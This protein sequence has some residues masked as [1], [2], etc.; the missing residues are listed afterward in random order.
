MTTIKFLNEDACNLSLS[1][2]SV[3]LIITSPPYAGIDPSRYGGNPSKQINANPEMKKTIKLYVKAVKEMERVIKDTGSIIMEIGHPNN[4]PYFLVSEVLKKTNLQLALP[5]FIQS[6]KHVDFFKERN[7]SERFNIAYTLWFHFSKNPDGIYFNPFFIKKDPFL[8]WE[9]DG[10]KEETENDKILSQIGNVSDC[11]N[12][13]IIKRFIETFSKPGQTVLDPFGGSGIT[14][15]TAYLNNRNA[16]TNDIS[17]EQVAVAKKR[18]E[19]E[20]KDIK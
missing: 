16:I 20:V 9:I 4:F 15:L 5:P 13:E 12:P 19:L 7:K 8:L 14:A 2:K 18:F 10:I 1:N 6:F 11:L 3:D 17:E